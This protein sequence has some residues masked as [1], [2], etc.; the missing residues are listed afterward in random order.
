MKG[1]FENYN[2]R[3]LIKEPTYFKNPENPSCTNLIL[4]EKRQ[5]FIKTGVI[6]T[7][8]SDYHKFVTT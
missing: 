3:Y 8:L 5:S 1:F 6:E 2:L 7:G 4:T